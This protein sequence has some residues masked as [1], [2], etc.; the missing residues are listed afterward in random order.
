M[1]PKRE[2]D[3][4]A[5]RL[6]ARVVELETCPWPEA[7][8]DYSEA[9]MALA[10]R[11]EAKPGK[12]ELMRWFE[13]HGGGALMA[14]GEAWRESLRDAFHEVIA[15]S[16]GVLQQFRAGLTPERAP[17]LRSMLVAC[18][19]WRAND[20]HTSFYRRH[21]PYRD[22][23]SVDSDR[24]LSIAGLHNPAIEAA[25]R[26]IWARLDPERPEH[27]A[28]MLVGM[29]FSVAEAAR[30][31]GCSRQQIYRSRAHFAESCGREGLA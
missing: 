14:Y 16:A 22:R 4:E 15:R 6:I 9:L 12:A 20:L 17:N 26:E 10:I 30:R 29:G 1:S 3:P 13:R 23:R 27:R 19:T 8:A 25:S 31:T 5:R 11:C 2:V 24:V 21:T 28:L 18:V 7:I